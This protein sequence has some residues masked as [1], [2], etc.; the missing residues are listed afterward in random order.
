[1]IVFS[2]VSAIWQLDPPGSFGKAKHGVSG[3]THWSL[4][5]L[6]IMTLIHLH[7]SFLC[8]NCFLT[9]LEVVMVQSSFPKLLPEPPCL[10]FLYSV[11]GYGSVLSQVPWLDFPPLLCHFSLLSQ[12][13]SIWAP[14]SVVSLEWWPVSRG[15]LWSLEHNCT[16]PVRPYPFQLLSQTT[17]LWFPAAIWGFS[18]PIRRMPYCFLVSS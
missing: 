7:Y 8:E 9:Y 2:V 1:M 5:F 10:L 16:S 15:S 17:P 18:S 14:F 6:N 13:S 3:R 12:L 4:C 11:E